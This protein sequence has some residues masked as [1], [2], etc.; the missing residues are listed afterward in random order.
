MDERE[1]LRV[2][3]WSMSFTG[4]W[5]IETGLHKIRDYPPEELAEFLWPWGKRIQQSAVYELLVHCNPRK[6]AKFVRTLVDQHPEL[7]SSIRSQYA[8]ME[9]YLFDTP[10]ENLPSKPSECPSDVRIEYIQ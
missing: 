6:A 3:P 2:Y 7:E 10:L 1:P 9:E 5:S 8:I 4:D